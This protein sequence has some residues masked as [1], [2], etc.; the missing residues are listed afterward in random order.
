M[1]TTEETQAELDAANAMIENL[2]KSLTTALEVIA[3]LMDEANR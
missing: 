2:K 3:R 1:K